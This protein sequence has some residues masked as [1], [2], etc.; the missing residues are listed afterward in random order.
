MNPG[1][2]LKDLVKLCRENN[3]TAQEKVYKLFYGT[4]MNV[5]LRYAKNPDDAVEVLNTGFLKVF[6][7]IDKYTGEGEMLH[8]WIRK[9]MVNT[10]LDK[11]RFE[12]NKY[13]NTVPLNIN[14]DSNY[15]ENDALSNFAEEDLI[16]MIQNLPPSSRTVFN[17]YVFENYNHKEIGEALNI[18]EST[19]QWHLLNARRI[20]M[21]R[22]TNLNIKESVING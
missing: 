3:S 9:I 1:K 13:S 7:N 12:K 22:I 6:Q 4:M 14:N 16:Q 18:S 8:A 21:K 19:S 17:M 2:E 15:I 10:A 11:I 20:L 5:C